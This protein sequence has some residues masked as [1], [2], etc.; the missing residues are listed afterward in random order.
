MQRVEVPAAGAEDVDHHREA[1]QQRGVEGRHC[2]RG[3]PR[4]RALQRGRDAL[5]FEL[6]HPEVGAGLEAHLK[7][8]RRA[9]NFAPAL[10]HAGQGGHR[11]CQGQQDLAF[12]D[13]G[14]LPGRVRVDEQAVAGQRGEQLDG[15]ALPRHRSHQHDAQKSIATATGRRMG[16]LSTFAVSRRRRP[17]GGS[18][19]ASHRRGV[20]PDRFPPR[21][22]MAALRGPSSVRPAG[23][24][25]CRVSALRRRPVAEALPHP[26]G[27]ASRLT[28]F[29]LGRPWPA[30]RGA[31]SVRPAGSARCRVSARSPSSSAGGPWRKRCRIPPARR[32]A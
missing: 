22:A 27:A 25:R 8:A 21:S 24:A 28:A 5:Q 1:G 9:P 7:A 4:L 32:R 12:D 2:D 17:V 10:R 19:A 15:H 29:R 20:A 31:S 18:A 23:S 6:A 11:A 3:P 14:S 30:P 16:R 26:T 13:L